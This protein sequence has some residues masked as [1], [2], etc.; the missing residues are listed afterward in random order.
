[1]AVWA[2]VPVRAGGKRL[3]GKGLATLGGRPLFVHVVERA[4]RAAV[5][6]VVVATDSSEVVAACK[7]HGLESVM[8]APA[9]CGTHRVWDAVQRLGG[10]PSVVLNVQGDQPLLD[11]SH[12]D[13]AVSLLERF[14]VGTVAAPLAD[15]TP[16]RRVKVV[17]APN[18][19]ALYFSR[20]PVP[21][22]GPYLM[23]IGVYAFRAPVLPAC[24]AAPRQQLARSEDLEQLAWLEAG[25][26]VGV[27]TV[28]SAEAPVDD[29][30]DLERVRGAL[31]P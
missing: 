26:A 14:D 30:H 15:P 22:G 17:T 20:A 4:A 16:A 27:Q 12:L 31:E 23:H 6:R 18:G 13:A 21:Y 10:T 25:I 28:T 5:D 3:P 7:A 9:P 1:V 24:V 2:V 11:P 8:T 19:R 29:K